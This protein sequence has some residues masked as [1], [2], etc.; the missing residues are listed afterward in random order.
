M[1]KVT[2]FLWFNA[3]A[4]EAAKFYV[5][6]F[7]NSRI[8]EVR[9]DGKRVTGVTFSLDGLELTA[10][11]GGPLFPFTEAISLCVACKAQKE[12]DRLW[13]RLSKGGRKQRCGWLKDRYG[14]SWQ[15]VPSVLA[16]LLGDPHPERSERVWKAMLKM[17]KLDIE[18]LRRAHGGSLHRRA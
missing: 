10:F 1:K 2:P 9:R 11:N 4:L 12:V 14:L 3:E 15:I 17:R 8:L 18:A 7:R 5:S 16:E 13:K 6:T